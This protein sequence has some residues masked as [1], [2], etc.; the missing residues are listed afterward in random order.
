MVHLY[1]RK[2][3]HHSIEKWNNSIK[4]PWQS[5]VEVDDI[6]DRS[7]FGQV[8]RVHRCVQQSCRGP[9]MNGWPTGQTAVPLPPLSS[10]RSHVLSSSLCRLTAAPSPPHQ[11]LSFPLFPVLSPTFFNGPPRA[12][13][14]FKPAIFYLQAQLGERRRLE[15]KTALMSSEGD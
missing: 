9:V 14:S 5:T 8:N 7:L 4:A 15:Q 12:P 11:H 2:R 1:C 10:P 3:T 6:R 13:L